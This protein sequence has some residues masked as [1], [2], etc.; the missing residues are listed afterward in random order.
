MEFLL[1]I[2]GGLASWVIAHLYYR[3]SSRQAPEWAKPLI[4]MLPDKALTESQLISLVQKYTQENPI[5]ESGVNANGEYLRYYNSV[6][7]CKGRFFVEPKAGQE[8]VQVVFPAQFI[9][10]PAVDISGEISQVASKRAT[11]S[12][13][14][15]R[16][17]SGAPKRR[18]EFGYQATGHWIDPKQP[19]PN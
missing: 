18:F 10:E 16:L 13:V 8:E 12:G 17:K 14:F 1:F 3:Q 11:E 7:V 9:G 15:I 19:V 2:L 6:Q 5:A 4:D